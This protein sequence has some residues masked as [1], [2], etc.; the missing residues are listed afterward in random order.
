MT[1]TDTFAY[2]I[3]SVSRIPPRM[4]DPLRAAQRKSADP[5]AAMRSFPALECN[6]LSVISQVVLGSDAVMVTTLTSIV[7]DL[8]S[9]RITL[10]G[11]E[12][13]MSTNYGIIRLK[14]H[15]LTLAASRFREFI[16]EAEQAALLEEERLLALHETGLG[17][18]HQSRG[19]KRRGARIN[20]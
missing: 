2:P 3:V 15:A 13:W 8:E 20:E 5:E 19:R 4:L 14:N 6:A 12:P 16:I 18:I 9:G 7:A 11:K 17:R 1:A 10:L